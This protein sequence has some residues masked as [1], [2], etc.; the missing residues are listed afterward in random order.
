MFRRILVPLDGSSLA[1]CVLPHAIAFSLANQSE[2]HLL[3]V[4]NSMSTDPNVNPGDPL[5]WKF[6]K[7]EADAYLEE[8]A[9]QFEVH[10]I[11]THLSTGEGRP[12]ET[13]IEVAHNRGIDLIVISSHGEHGLTGWNIS[14]VV[15]KVI[16]R[17]PTSILL[18]RAYH[19]TP[20]EPIQYKRLML[21]LDGSRRAESVLQ[22]AFDLA[23]AWEAELLVTHVVARPE[24]PR[25]RPLSAQEV[26][27]AESVV[28]SNR[29]EAA[30][31]LAELKQ[32]FNLPL[33]THLFI[34]NKVASRLHRFVDE[35]AVDLVVLTAHGFAGKAE[36][37]YGSVVTTF[38][39]YGTTPILVYQDI[40]AEFIPVTPAEAA[41]E[42]RGDH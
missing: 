29:A 23:R 7:V 40:P 6:R 33:D 28:E 11:T 18:I 27:L 25:R 21:P 16:L 2:V 34:S 22:T 1:E 19:T 32:R 14:S 38:I 30:Q 17:A 3:R 41:A 13:I 35:Q 4:V 9:A 36:W 20:A 10:G 37:A 5:E 15:Q 31:Y 12:A 8:I 39:V 42:E 26:E 24:M